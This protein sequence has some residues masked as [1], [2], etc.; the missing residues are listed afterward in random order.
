MPE[1]VKV[2]RQRIVENELRIPFLGNWVFRSISFIGDD[3]SPEDVDLDLMYVGKLEPI[4]G[5]LDNWDGES[6]VLDNG[7]LLD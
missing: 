6:I 1:I 4:E 2:R 7:W 5:T 3:G